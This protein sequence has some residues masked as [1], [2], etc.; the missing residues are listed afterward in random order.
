MKKTLIA[1]MALAGISYGFT[2]SDANDWLQGSL[3][4][5]I[6]S[7]TITFQIDDNWSKLGGENIFTFNTGWHIRHEVAQYLGFSTNGTSVTGSYNSRNGADVVYN[8]DLDEL[9]TYQGWFFDGSNGN[10]QKGLKGV[11]ITISGDAQTGTSVT[12]IA[13]EKA[14]TL[15]R[16]I[17]YAPATD[18]SFGF[19]SDD[20]NL[21][22][23][24][25]MKTLSIEYTANGVTYAAA[26]P[27]SVTPAVPEPAT[28]TLSLLALAG[29]CARRRRA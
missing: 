17:Y 10:E 29:L 3:V 28:A 8:I 13:S 18:G 15:T 2:Y 12:L 9:K 24:T 20:T 7:Y 26:Y 16:D 5:D 11:C 22:N 4:S 6:T 27:D 21:K 23:G 25:F 1:L 14:I 19:L